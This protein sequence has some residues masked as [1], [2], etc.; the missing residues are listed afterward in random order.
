MY[1]R[2][3]PL[4]GPDKEPKK[5]PPKPVLKAVAHLHPMFR[6]RARAAT[7][8]LRDRPWL[9]VLDRWER[10]MKPDLIS[11]NQAYQ[12]VEP[13]GL[14]DGELADH[15]AALC[16][17]LRST[18]ETH[19]WLHG[20]DL[21]PL[22]KYLHEC[23]GWGIPAVEAVAALAG[24]SPSTAAPLKRL[25]PLRRL[26]EAAGTRPTSLAEVRAISPQ[27][28]ALLDEHLAEYG[29]LLV[30]RYDVDGLT[31]NELPGTVLATILDAREPPP[32]DHASVTSRLRAR[33]PAV[34]QPKFD[35]GLSDARAVMNLRDDN[36]PMTFEW[37]LGLLRRALL[38]AGRR[39]AVKHLLDEPE[40]VFELAHHEVV[41]L[42]R[43]GIGPSKATVGACAAERRRL[44][45]LN[46][47]ITLGPDEPQPAP[48]VLPQPLP[49]MVG[50]VQTALT[51]LA[52]GAE[53]N[54]DRMTGAGI[55]TKTYRGRVRRAGSPEEAID[56]LE[57]GDVLVVR[58]T[59]PAFNA[60]LPLA[61]AIITADGGP[62]S[63][64][65]VLARE[66][67]I[68]AVVGVPAAMELE[69]G[70][71]V[72]VDPVRGRVTLVTT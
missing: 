42:V 72:D 61:G 40:H 24:A 57:P 2:L 50:M 3:L 28:S 59:S 48:D 23:V 70:A 31:L 66:L 64:A 45:E 51:Q 53:R 46:P 34:D 54:S 8:T 36:G 27:A 69:D 33:V 4:I 25:V 47:P 55:G 13:T 7:A 26:I 29:H 68:P 14:G 22:A 15:I 49:F 1:T 19:F 30:T 71:Q 35:V 9:A 37:P 56:L 60:I 21:G 38:E 18:T 65:A 58:A 63:H 20:F 44:V 17:H 43:S 52:M 11:K 5:L 62:M 12:T 41:T 32:Y 67:G 39:L 16:A 6:A 10:E